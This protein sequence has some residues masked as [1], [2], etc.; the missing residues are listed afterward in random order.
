MKRG[1][2]AWG[3]LLTAVVC[4]ST[5][6]QVA[7]MMVC[8]PTDQTVCAVTRQELQLPIS[9]EGTPLKIL[10]VLSYEGAFL[11]DG[12]NTPVAEVLCILVENTGDSHIR[13]ARIIL[14]GEERMYSFQAR[15]LPPGSRT[16]LLETGGAP[17][18]REG[19][20]CY[21]CGSAETV[22]EDLL[23]AGQLE[24]T[25]VDM[26]SV[27]V[28]NCSEQTLTDLE[29]TY[30]NY[31]ADADVYQGGISYR[32][33]LPVLQPGET[34]TINPERYAS[35]YSRFVYACCPSVLP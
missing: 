2:V 29:L 6:L 26:G 25:P 10:S 1:W 12:G 34:V 5:A 18:V 30:K 32:H 24:I 3:V 23:T 19:E 13:S 20:F 28:T 31:L 4:Y 17:W 9:L 21:A 14:C 16:I 11:E 8:R 22:Q 35:G 33:V 15:D 27:A 7:G